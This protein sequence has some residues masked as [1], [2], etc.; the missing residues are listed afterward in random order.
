MEVSGHFVCADNPDLISLQG[1]P[2]EVG[3]DFTCFDNPN[4]ASLDGIGNVAGRIFSDLS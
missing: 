2:K 3:G 1:A 4:L